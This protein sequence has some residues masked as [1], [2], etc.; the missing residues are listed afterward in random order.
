MSTPASS[1]G[2]ATP[3][4][5]PA[6]RPQQW[7]TLRPWLFD[8]TAATE[9]LRAA[10]RRAQPLPVEAWA[11]AYGLLPSGTPNAVSLLGPGPG[12]DPYYAMTTDLDQPV[13]IA[14]LTSPDGEPAGLLLIDGCH[15]LY[16][17]AATGRVEIPALVLTADETR[18]IR[19][20]ATLGP[21]RR[22]PAPPARPPRPAGTAPH[23]HH[24]HG[25]DHR[26]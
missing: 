9:L 25:D 11:R 7:F 4:R 17:A 10:P 2:G 18:A 13:I 5:P 12:F 16:K 1:R 8:V 3:P 23:P 14:T 26:C 6:A 24:R 21:P 22:P 19:H 20:D 15:R